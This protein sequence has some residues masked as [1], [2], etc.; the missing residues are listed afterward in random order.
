MGAAEKEKFG[1]F[2][3]VDVFKAL[4]KGGRIFNDS[5]FRVVVKRESKPEPYW[6]AICL[7]MNIVATGYTQHQVIEN[8][9]ALMAFHVVD[10]IDN[11][12]EKDIF[13]PAPAELWKPFIK[14]R[15]VPEN[16]FPHL[17]GTVKFQGRNY[18]T[19]YSFA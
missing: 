19:A 10:Y 15:K 14:A 5:Q 11:D 12:I 13:I 9:I 8:L 4:E 17:P 7:E 3:A 16:Y 6:C 2:L 1:D 18:G